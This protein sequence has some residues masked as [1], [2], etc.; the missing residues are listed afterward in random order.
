MTVGPKITLTVTGTNR[1]N[2]SGETA[3]PETGGS[4]LLT[5]T[6]TRADQDP[7]PTLAHDEATQTTGQVQHQLI[8]TLTAPVAQLA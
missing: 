8:S 5:T 7:D 6:R 2:K 1:A 4:S 3:G